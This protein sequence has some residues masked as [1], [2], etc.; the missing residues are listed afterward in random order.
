MKQ[1]RREGVLEAI[2]LGLSLKF[3]AMGLRILQS[4]QDID[5]LDEMISGAKTTPHVV[6]ESH[7]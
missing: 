4:V 6:Q 2:E 7:V 3:G 5:D 1:G